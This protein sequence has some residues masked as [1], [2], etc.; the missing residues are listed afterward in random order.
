MQLLP[1]NLLVG[2]KAML[3]KVTKCIA[4]TIVFPILGCVTSKQNLEYK[5]NLNSMQTKINAQQQILKSTTQR[6]EKVKKDQKG[7]LRNLSKVNKEYKMLEGKNQEL[8]KRIM[9]L[10]RELIEVTSR[11]NKEYKMLEG[12]NQELLKRIMALERELTEVTSALYEIIKKN[13]QK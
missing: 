7:Y 12:K 11:V 13:Q 8:L 6:L 3:V 4:L 2:E 1:E 5:S 10:E 9:A